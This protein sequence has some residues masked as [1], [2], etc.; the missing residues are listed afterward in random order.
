MELIDLPFTGYKIEKRKIN[1]ILDEIIDSKENY[2]DL[3]EL[4]NKYLFSLQDKAE[5]RTYLISTLV[6]K[7]S[8]VFCINKEKAREIKEKLNPTDTS[9]N[10]SCYGKPISISIIKR[11]FGIDYPQ[12]AKVLER[13][14]ESGL[15][16][17]DGQGNKYLKTH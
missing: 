4:S 8:D 1:V 3:A 11:N 14:E 16:I 5:I 17:T 9:E 7:P 15:V 6:I 12:A 13:L 2:I 10:D